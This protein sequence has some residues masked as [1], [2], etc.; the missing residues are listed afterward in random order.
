MGLSKCLRLLT[1]V[2]FFSVLS[3]FRS[4][5]GKV[6][7]CMSNAAEVYH[8]SRDCRGLSNCKHEIIEVSK[9]EAVNS[10]GRRICGWED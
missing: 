10:Y 7:L 4:P 9:E 8:Y 2:I 3:S 5:E 6:Y 1:L